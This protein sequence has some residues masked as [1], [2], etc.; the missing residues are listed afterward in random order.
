MKFADWLLWSHPELDGK[1]VLD[2]RYELLSSDEIRRLVLFG[3][4]SATDRPL[5]SPG[6]Y[7]LDPTTEQ[8]AIT[9]LRPRVHVVYDTDRVFVAE[10]LD[11]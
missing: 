6:I 4:G 3:A 2:A 1:V 7:V 10:A 11:R 9:A 8:H 5:G